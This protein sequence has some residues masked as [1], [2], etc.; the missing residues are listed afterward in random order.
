MRVVGWN[1]KKNLTLISIKL[2]DGVELDEIT[3]AMLKYAIH[4][5]HKD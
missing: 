1:S 5:L 3:L 2:E 4:F